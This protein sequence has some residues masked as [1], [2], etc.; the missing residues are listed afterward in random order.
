MLM[1]MSTRETGLMTRLMVRELTLTQMELITM[2][3]G[4]MTNNMGLVWKVG[5]MGQSMRASIRMERKTARASSRLLMAATM[6]VS[7]NKTKYA[8]EASII[9]QMENNT[10]AS[11]RRI[12][13][14]G[15][16]Y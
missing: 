14:M 9:G 2:E 13:C 6:T 4:S 10:K 5:L 7:S 15:K 8:G 16:D 1:G 12:K 11:G 3:I